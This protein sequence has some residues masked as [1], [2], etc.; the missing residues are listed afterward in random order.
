M[1]RST[2][3]RLALLVGVIVVMGGLAYAANRSLEQGTAKSDPA[4]PPAPSLAASGLPVERVMIQGQNF[5]LE[6]AATEADIAKGL[7]KRTEIPPHTGMIFVFPSGNER[8]FWMV[9]CLIDMDIAY[10]ATDGTVLTVY[11]MKMEPLRGESESKLDYENRL[12]R[13]LSGSGVQFAIETPAGTNDALKIKPGVKI[14]IDRKSLLNH[15][16]ARNAPPVP[17]P[18]RLPIRP[19]PAVPPAPAT[20]PPTR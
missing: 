18:P 19:V 10:L 13:Y 9:D 1:K 3:I 6:V 4:G 8:S 15:W 12:K 14:P 7:S 17:T 11:S 16:R 20:P 2:S 5:D